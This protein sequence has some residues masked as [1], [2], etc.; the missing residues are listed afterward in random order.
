MLVEQ[1][2]KLAGK[3]LTRQ[4]IIDIMVDAL[5]H[6]NRYN[7]RSIHECIRLALNMEGT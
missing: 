4:E 2:E 3:R 1:L 7:G 5:D 6:M